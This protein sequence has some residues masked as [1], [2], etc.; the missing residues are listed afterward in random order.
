MNLNKKK[1]ETLFT[2]KTKSLT[3]QQIKR[4][5]ELIESVWPEDKTIEELVEEYDI[6]SEDTVIVVWDNGKAI[7]HARYFPRIIKAGLIDIK[8]LCLGG[9]CVSPNRRKENLGKFISK[10]AFEVIDK[11]E[12]SF[13]L[14]Q[15]K[16]PEFYKKIGGTEINNIFYNSKNINN[17]H[18][19]PWWDD[20]IMVY[21]KDIKGWPI[22]SI[23]LNGSAY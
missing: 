22:C 19:S 17:P 18:K 1:M 4:I 21:A 2:H 8:V 6:N 10:K 15:T 9:V 14:F 7:A 3:I 16:V 13:C 11:R 20:H 12:F 5:V 23:D